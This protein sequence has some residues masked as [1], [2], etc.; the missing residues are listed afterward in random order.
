V[1]FSDSDSRVAPNTAG[2][3]RRLPSSPRY[4]FKSRLGHL[5]IEDA[6]DLDS[7]TPCC[8]RNWNNLHNQSWPRCYHQEDELPPIGKTSLPT[9]KLM[10]K[11]I[12]M[13]KWAAPSSTQ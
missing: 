8:T 10:R 1:Y 2:N 9:A 13:M 11:M 6:A 12:Q 7:S 3:H 4:S 5:R